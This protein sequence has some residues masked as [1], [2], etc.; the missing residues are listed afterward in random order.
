[1]EFKSE[2]KVSVIVI[3]YNH[4]NYIE[5]CL[6]SLF[7]Q[8]VNFKVE[9]IIGDDCSKDDTNSIINSIIKEYPQLNIHYTRNTTNQGLMKNFKQCFDACKGKY[10][11]LCAGDD[12]WISDAKLQKQY[13][14][15]ESYPDYICSSTDTLY[16]DGNDYRPYS[17]VETKASWLVEKVENEFSFQ[18]LA[19]RFFPHPNTMF[20]INQGMLPEYF[21][22][23][24][25]EDYPLYLLLSSKGKVHFFNEK[26][27]AYRIHGASYVQSKKSIE[28]NH[29]YSLRFL[30]IQF[31]MLSELRASYSS[32]MIKAI[33]NE[34][35]RLLLTNIKDNAFLKELHQHLKRLDSSESLNLNANWKKWKL[36]STFDFYKKNL[37]SK[38]KSIKSRLKK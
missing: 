11:A 18:Q 23:F 32:K 3:V 20:F 15:L 16:L 37:K 13:D 2:I 30:E 22:D 24:M 33:E 36:K 5:Q 14:Y 8:K 29:Q 35:K 21:L 27:T 25:C 7:S 38:L 28:T 4:E 10:V 17:Y 1:L 9:Y 12:Y 34:V 31:T 19:N 26:M 6:T